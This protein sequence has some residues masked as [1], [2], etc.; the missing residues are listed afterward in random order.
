MAEKFI[1]EFEEKHHILEVDGKEYEVPQ[2]TAELEDKISEREKTLGEKTEYESNMSLLEILFG[3]KAAKTMFP[4]EKTTNLDK[5]SKCAKMALAAYYTTLENAKEE[6]R[7]KNMAKVERVLEKAKQFVDGA[8]RMD[9]ISNKKNTEKFIN[10]K[11][12]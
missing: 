2:R 3:K 9:K 11:K 7:E 4:S 8:E 6:D 1:L 12:K 5:L 10:S